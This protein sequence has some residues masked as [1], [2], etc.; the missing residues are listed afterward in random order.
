MRRFSFLILL[1]CCSIGLKSQ[2]L[3]S[4]KYLGDTFSAYYYIGWA[5]SHGITQNN[6]VPGAE[7]QNLTGNFMELNFKYHDYQ[8]G[9]WQFD[10]RTKMYTDIIK[11]LA[12][13]ILGTES[14]Y[15]ALENTGLT[16]GPLG[17]HTY[18]YNLIAGDYI[19]ISPGAH[20]NDYFYFANARESETDARLSTKEPQGYYF[21]AGP[22]LMLSLYASKF[23]MINLKSQYSF[24]YWRPVSVADAIKDDNYPLPQFFGFTTELLTPWGI[25]FEVDHNRLI[26]KGPNPNEGMRTDF[27]I[28]F[29]FVVN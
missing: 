2:N 8:K 26:N 9:H 22:S 28:G 16:T 18:T 11:Q 14:A 4:F 13:L 7:N 27:N 6:A 25:Y 12:D 17:W 24:A 3:Q 10:L 29:K 23:L 20:H 15:T 19:T 21:A 5:Y 1:I